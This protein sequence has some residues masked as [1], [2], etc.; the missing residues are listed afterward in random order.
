[1]V[2]KT[3]VRNISS[4]RI[5][6]AEEAGGKGANMGEMV[7]AKL[8]VPPG[9]VMLRDCY[10]DS[11]REGGVYEELGRLHREALAADMTHMPELCERLQGLVNKAGVT[12]AVRDLVLAAYR[13]LG[14]DAAVAVRSSATGE[15]GRDASFA[16][17][18][19]TIT[20]VSG[21]DG[22]M[23]AVLKCWIPIR[24]GT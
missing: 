19:A 22:L 20:N 14:A 13:E 4:L 12:D 3:Y 16:G 8:P 18:N 21:E 5:S 6:D 2:G 15:D 1:M 11:M 10:R 9:F 24:Q 23:D 7:A 17:M